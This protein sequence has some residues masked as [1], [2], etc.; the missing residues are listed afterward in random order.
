[1]RRTSRKLIHTDEQDIY[2]SKGRPLT[3]SRLNES[4]KKSKKHYKKSSIDEVHK[5]GDVFDVSKIEEPVAA[6][7]NCIPLK[8]LP[9]PGQPRTH[10][11][12][13]SSTS[14]TQAPKCPLLSLSAS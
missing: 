1:M 8:I 7:D 9:H 4:D 13:L 3:L 12:P 11:R 14:C 2:G 10:C 5:S 6:V